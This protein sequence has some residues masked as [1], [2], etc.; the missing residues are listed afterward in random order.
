MLHLATVEPFTL[1]L[2]KRLKKLFNYDTHKQIIT[3]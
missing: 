1:E 3:N 2:L